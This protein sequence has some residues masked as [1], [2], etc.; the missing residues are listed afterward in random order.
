MSAKPI[1]DTILR[2]EFRCN[3]HPFRQTCQNDS[4]DISQLP[5][6]DM[7][8]HRR[9]RSQSNRTFLHL[10]HTAISFHRTL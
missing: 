5:L 4:R 10:L 8:N 2:N 9:K 1:T 3:E 6:V 7:N